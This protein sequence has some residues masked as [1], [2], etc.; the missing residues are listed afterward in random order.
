MLL[1]PIF[2]KLRDRN[3]LV[4]GAGKIS[5]G[6]I[7]GILPTGA[8]IRVVAPEATPHI[9]QWHRA[10]KLSWSQREYQSSDLDG[11]FMV[12]AATSS[13]SLHHRIFSEAHRQ[14]VLCNI[15]DVPDLCD[16]YYPAV[17]R[18]GELQIAISTGGSSPALAQRLRRQ[19]ERDFG[20]EYD[21]WLKHLAQQ[22]KEIRSSRISPEERNRLLHHQASP[23]SFADFLQSTKPNK[24][25]PRPG[26]KSKK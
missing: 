14:A 6:K 19:L 8:K 9:Q 26:A 7:A 22:R 25:A 23:E 2:V 13:A 10:K 20:P 12:V 5:E 16:F 1:F 18:R 24:P 3:V 15:V 11:A 21:L 17:V 4:V